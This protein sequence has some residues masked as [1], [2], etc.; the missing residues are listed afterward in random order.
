MYLYRQALLKGIASPDIP[1][2]ASF[3]GDETLSDWVVDISIVPSAGA[4]DAAGKQ[5]CTSGHETLLAPCSLLQPGAQM[6]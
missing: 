2:I 3:L 6:L 1:I 4:I 5:P